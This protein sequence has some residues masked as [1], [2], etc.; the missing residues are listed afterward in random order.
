MTRDRSHSRLLSVTV[1]VGVLAALAGGGLVGY[2]QLAGTESGDGPDVVSE[3]PVTEMDLRGRMAVTSPVVA[4][5]PTEPDFLAAATQGDA[6]GPGCALQVSGDRGHS[7]VQIEAVGTFPEGIEACYQPQVAFAADGRLVFSFVGM[8]GPPPAPDGVFVV[9]SDD[10]GQTFTQPRRLADLDTITPRMTVS[11]EGIEMV[12][13]DPVEEAEWGRVGPPWPMGPQLQAAIGDAG[14]LDEPVVVAEPD[15]LVAAPTIAGDPDG[16]AAVAYYELRAAARPD[17]G[18]ASL[19]GE[20]PWRLMVAQRTGGGAGGFGE[21]VEVAE[22]EW[23]DQ[24][25]WESDLRAQ[26]DAPEGLLPLLL[27]RWSIAEPGLAVR[28]GHVC[29]SWT[30]GRDDGLQALVSCS[31]GESGWSSPTRLGAEADGARVSWLP[32]VAISRS[33]QVQAVFHGRDDAAGEAVDA[34]YASADEPGAEFT[35]V[36]RL[37]SRPSSPYASP[38]PGWYGSR[39]GLAS[40]ADT[41]VAMWA[42]SRNASELQPGQTLFSAVVDTPVG[43]PR[44]LGWVAGGLLVGGLVVAAGGLVAGRR[45]RSAGR[46]ESVDVEASPA[47]EEVRP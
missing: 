6:P 5:D 17:G 26:E 44:P 22:L 25:V 43:L 47:S 39:V 46:P 19:A 31:T 8:A 14:G 34:W 1:L 13:V 32:Q 30:D 9:V 41:A 16:G 27:T 28:D 33:G 12:W 4:Q 40:G 35:D 45:Q 24:A 10:R 21:P 23:A 20:G 37:T 11:A 15:G 7:W 42:D 18:V 29:V 36:V 38:R 2:M 3:T